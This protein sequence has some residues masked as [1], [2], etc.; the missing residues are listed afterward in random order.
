MDIS[1]AVPDDHEVNDDTMNLD[2]AQHS[3]TPMGISIKHI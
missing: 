3:F 2:T 1:L